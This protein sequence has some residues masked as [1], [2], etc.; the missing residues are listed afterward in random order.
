METKKIVAL[1]V[2]ILA[3]VNM[4]LKA[5][6]VPTLDVTEDMIYTIASC[7]V[8][9]V[10][11]AS[12]IWYNFNFTNAAK[13]GQKVTDAIKAAKYEEDNED[14]LYSDDEK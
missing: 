1:I 12:T 7:V 8:M 11:W 6:N 2:A 3:A 10:S 13:E 14:Y 4:I 9:V 5:F